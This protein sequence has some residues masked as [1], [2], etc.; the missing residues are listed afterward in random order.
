M[1]RLNILLFVLFIFSCT[2]LD[3]FEIINT[4]DPNNPFFL[5]PPDIVG[6][7]SYDD[8][9]LILLFEPSTA[10]SL[11]VNRRVDSTSLIISFP[12][13]EFT[14]FIIDSSNIGLNKEY[15]Y[16]LWFINSNGNSIVNNSQTHYHDFPGVDTFSVEQ[17]NE[18]QVRLNW[19]YCHD[20]HFM[21]SVDSL[22][23][24]IEKITYNAS[25]FIDS[26]VIDT[27]FPLNQNCFYEMQDHVELGD[28]VIYSLRVKRLASL[29]GSIEATAISIIFP[30]LHDYGWIPINSHTVQIEWT[31]ENINM[32]YIQSVLLFNNIDLYSVPLYE[33]GNDISGFY[34]DDISSYYNGI[35]AGENI[36]YKLKWCGVGACDSTFINATT[37]PIYNMTYVHS[38]SNVEFIV[39]DISHN[40]DKS[41][42]FYIDTHE[43]SDLIFTDPGLNSP[44]QLNSLPK[45]SINFFQARIFC[46]NRSTE[47]NSIMENGFEFEH[48]YSDPYSN[49]TYDINKTGFHIANELEWEISAGYKYD[50]QTGTII[51]FF[52]YPEPVGSG[53]LSCLF[54]N[55]LGCFDEASLVGYYDGTH[56]PYQFSTSFSGIYDMSGNLKEWVEK[57]FIHTDSREILR[58]GDF[59]TQWMD[60]KSTSY[61]YVNGDAIHRTIGFRTAIL[62]EPFLSSWYIVND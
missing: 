43:V 22:N 44:E 34:I 59:M 37:F 38:L 10:D 17:L 41:P 50:S 30:S 12:I 46:N 62:A 2:K 49:T 42:A 14:S 20:E 45:D 8:N 18:S 32:N 33:T 16:D 54:A 11:I 1:I 15:S 57:Y 27:V 56:Y 6:I 48:V 35:E 53:E 39:E 55:Y 28:S 58:G 51:N 61:I 23:W 26:S 7:D 5:S 3:V 25:S 36:V 21:V 60:C 52:P 31:L 24:L 29:S 40:I 13:N 47:L 4:L 19:E 9:A